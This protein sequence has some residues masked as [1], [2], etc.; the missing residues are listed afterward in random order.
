MTNADQ[1]KTSLGSTSASSDSSKRR[2]M[3]IEWIKDLERGDLAHKKNEKAIH[4]RRTTSGEDLFIQ[5]PGKESM[6]KKR[7]RPW[8]FRPKLC[9]PDDT[10]E[11]YLKD[12]S[13]KDIWDVIIGIIND[14]MQK[15]EEIA[16]L[17]AITFYRMAF[18]LDHKYDETSKKRKVLYLEFNDKGSCSKE[19][20]LEVFERGFLEYSPPEY[21]L[22]NFPNLKIE[23]DG[24]KISL[25][26]FLLYNELLA[27]N[28]DCKYY[29]RNQFEK[30]SGWLKGIGKVNNLLSHISIIGFLI[31][32]IKLSEM[33]MQFTR[34]QGVGP[35]TNKQIK[36][37][38]EE[39]LIDKRQK[40]QRT[41][42][43]YRL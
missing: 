35:A 23:I 39:F 38:C 30:N 16:S 37:I 14:P 27:W 6:N 17:L 12:L 22:D 21:I 20:H 19:E 7:P 1:L 29:Y 25:E 8:D 34:G 36:E 33:V 10:A 26:A 42:F 41:I 40:Q 31:G 13:F 3:N 28:E 15:K 43:E 2:M 9:K 11:K 18:M 5:Y 32:K 24:M 4:I